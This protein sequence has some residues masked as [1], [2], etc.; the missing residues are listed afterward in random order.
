MLLAVEGGGFFSSSAS[1][2]SHGLALL[3]LG[4]KNDEKPVKVSPWNHYRLVEREEDRETR[5]LASSKNQVSCKCT[6]FGC[7]GCMPATL[8][9]PVNTRQGSACQS[10][11]GF[12][13]TKAVYRDG[14]NGG[15]DKR[16]C[17]KSNLKRDS[18][19]QCLVFGD[20]AVDARDSVEEGLNGNLG[21]ERRKVQWTDT[22]GKEL[23]EIRE[24]EASERGA[25]DDEFENE[26]FK[27]CECTIM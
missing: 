4:R 18:S 14:S 26:S 27:K 24:F 16:G 7:F 15:G 19:D 8:D 1:G 11:K 12:R 3:L 6:A 25:S 10:E 2:Y 22:C 23:V 21:V 5:Q 13:G 17:L 9:G 20:S